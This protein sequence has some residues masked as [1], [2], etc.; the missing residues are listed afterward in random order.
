L[1]RTEQSA[2][3]AREKY[4]ADKILEVSDKV[5]ELKKTHKWFLDLASH[6]PV[7][8]EQLEHDISTIKHE[9]QVA[10]ASEAKLGQLKVVN[11]RQ[12]DTTD[13]F[14]G[15]VRQIIIESIIIFLPSKRTIT[16]KSLTLTL[17]SLIPCS[18]NLGRS[19]I[20]YF[21]PKL[22]ESLWI[23]IQ[24]STTMLLSQLEMME[25]QK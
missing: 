12:D 21:S 22:Q 6:S 24:T 1:R 17:A 2:Q 11:I 13:P 10:E 9:I 8:R 5:S 4:G 16:G 15:Y 3:L 19:F 25:N 23:L 20:A 7:M 18:R 14:L